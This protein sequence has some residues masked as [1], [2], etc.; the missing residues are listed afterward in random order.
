MSD[1][2][3][4]AAPI[5][6]TLAEGCVIPAHPLALDENG[7]FDER[8][9][10][11]LTR[12]YA[13]ARAGGLAVGVHTTQF[14]IREPGVDLFEPV[15]A[16]AAETLEAVDR[17]GRRPLIRIAGVCGDTGQA[18]REAGLAR[19]LGYHLALVSL[20]DLPAGADDGALVA[21]CDAVA[22]VL[23]IMGFYLQPAVGGRR[24]GESFWRRFADIPNAAAVKI[25]PFDRYMTLEAV[26]GIASSGRGD[27]V[28]LYTGNDDHIVGDLL[29]PFDAPGP[30]DS[31][32]RMRFVGGLLGHWAVWTRPAV[33]VFRRVRDAV[34]DGG[35]L[36]S[37]LLSLGARI[38]QMN[39]AV[40]DV[41]HEFAG[42]IAGVQHVLCKQGL[43]ASTRTLDSDERLSPGQAERIDRA[44]RENPDLID[45]DFVAEHL[46][47]WLA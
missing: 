23:P 24:L 34:R 41:A 39:A 11:A 9:Q 40:F 5:A 35:A 47:E 25:A 7:R 8:H 26:R 22:R 21:H 14:A 18:V 44:R 38:T 17:Q 4:L 19:D 6:E 31:R 1:Y 10:R 42:C 29:T 43:L 33:R 3:Q 32:R 2:P 15:L 46:D 37:D 36:P 45:D 16:L 30:D 28:A 27:R 13:A 12:Y 20:R